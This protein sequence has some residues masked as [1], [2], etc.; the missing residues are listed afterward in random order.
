MI[1]FSI[2]ASLAF[3]CSKSPVRKRWLG[4]LPRAVAEL[5]HRWALRLGQ[6]FEGDDVSCG[7]V[8]PATRIDGTSVVLKLGMP[9]FERQHEI[10]GLRLMSGNPTVKLLEADDHLN[11]MLLER[12]MPGT[13]LR[14]VPEA[15]QDVVI[16]GL[17]KRFWRVPP[18]NHPFRHLSE[19]LRYWSEETERDETRWNDPGL[20]REGLRAFEQMGRVST[21]DVLLAT[22]LHAGNVLKAEREPWLVVD[23]KPFLGDKAYDATQHLLNSRARL[24][25]HPHDTINSFADLLEVDRERVRVW[26]FAR[27]AAEP[28]DDWDDESAALARIVDRPS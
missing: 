16:A 18:P 6:P 12:C 3:S 26:T 11:A 13:S 24:R 19:M 9:H 25:S 28:R 14:E 10:E 23:P 15:Q 21:S 1:R 17:L 4:D 7:W 8:A 20:V 22:D 2:P 5:K 27:L